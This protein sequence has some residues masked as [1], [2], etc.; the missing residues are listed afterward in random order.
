MTPYFRAE[1]G[2]E[3][4]DYERW[5]SEMVGMREILGR[6]AN[7]SGEDIIGM[8]APYLKP[9]RNSQYEVGLYRLHHPFN[10]DTSLIFPYSDSARL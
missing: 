8:R 2:L 5:A 7:I 4:E 9:G 3:R 6:F 1:R 10:P